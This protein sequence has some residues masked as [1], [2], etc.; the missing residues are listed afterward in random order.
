[1]GDTIS[2]TYASL[3]PMQVDV[4]CALDAFRPSPI[5]KIALFMTMEH[6]KKAYA[7][8]NQSAHRER[9][10]TYDQM[11]KFMSGSSVDPNKV[12]YLLRRGIKTSKR[13][14]NLFRFS[15]DVRVNDTHPFSMEHKNSLFYM[16]KIRAA[17]LFIKTDDPTFE[18][19]PQIFAEAVDVFK[20]N[21][22]HFKMIRVKGTHHVHLNNPE[23]IAPEISDFL[24]KYHIEEKNDI[25][26]TSV[27]KM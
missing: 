16:K 12:S 17:Y 5:P 4:V 7:S 14:P 19:E 18:E 13:N 23:S 2:F 3:F 8:N 27:C 6:M 20:K 1:M 21:N 9:E 25:K 22:P 11:K 10:Y 15:H 26:L 24:K